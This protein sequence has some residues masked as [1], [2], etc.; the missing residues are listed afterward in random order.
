M[1]KTSSKD[2]LTIQTPRYNQIALRGLSEKYGFSKRYLRQ[3]LSGERKAN[4]SETITKEYKE[5]VSRIEEAI[6]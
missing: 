1:K 6:K 5:F 3:I 2:G 4:I